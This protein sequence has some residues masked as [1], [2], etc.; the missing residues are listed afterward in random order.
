M[1]RIASFLF[2]FGALLKVPILLFPAR[3]QI[4]I[5]YKLSRST[6]V[7]STI[8][9]I[10]SFVSFGV[11]CVYPDVTNL[12][13]LLGGITIGTCG[14]SVPLLLKISSNSRKKFSASHIVYPIIFVMV[15]VVQVMSAYVSIKDSISKS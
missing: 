15:V 13:G 14:F 3:E 9:V 1:M 11:P 10:L 12:L 2:T 8:T 7:H 6:L 5:F 4:Y